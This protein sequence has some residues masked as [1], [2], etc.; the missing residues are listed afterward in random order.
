[1]EGT[2]NDSDIRA[3][4]EYALQSG[5]RVALSSFI[6]RF[7]EFETPPAIMVK[8]VGSVLE[9]Y[10][11]D[12][13]SMDEAF[14]LRRDRKGRPDSLLNREW[15]KTDASMVARWRSKGLSLEEATWK[16]T[17]FRNV[18]GE[19]TSETTVRRNYRKYR[20]T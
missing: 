8:A 14:N 16:T 4:T 3:F 12:I 15:A 17:Q 13:V 2:A 6:A 10:R 11:C 18:H 5:D 1:M 19:V 7:N 20:V 9:K